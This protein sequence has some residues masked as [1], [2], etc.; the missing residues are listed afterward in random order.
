MKLKKSSSKLVKAVKRVLYI[1]SAY[2]LYLYASEIV[3][4]HKWGLTLPTWEAIIYLDICLVLFGGVLCGSLLIIIGNSKLDRIFG[5][6]MILINIFLG[7][8]FYFEASV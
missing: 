5:I 4:D 1:T 2:I 3:N 6:V 8:Y 7:S